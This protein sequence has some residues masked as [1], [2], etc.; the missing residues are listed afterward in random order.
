MNS[1]RNGMHVVGDGDSSE[2]VDGPAPHSTPIRRIIPLS[3]PQAKEPTVVHG[4]NS[5]VF[6]VLTMDS[7]AYDSGSVPAALPT[8]L[9][10][11]SGEADMVLSSPGGGMS[12]V[13]SEDDLLESLRPQHNPRV[14]DLTSYKVSHPFGPALVHGCSRMTIYLLGAYSTVSVS[15]CVDCEI[16]VGAVGGCVLMS[17]CERVQIT[18]ACRKMVIWSCHDCDVRLATL[19]PSIMSGDCR[20]LVFGKRLSPVSHL[21]SYHACLTISTQV[22]STRH[23]ASSEYTSALLN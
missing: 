16:V 3:S 23:I 20:K 1:P 12:S 11:I 19:T 5:T 7:A 22:L 18:V 17:S 10:S 4:S 9:R 14:N 8:K 6:N 2:A 21:Q 13:G 15:S